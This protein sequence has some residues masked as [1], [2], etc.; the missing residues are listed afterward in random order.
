MYALQLSNTLVRL[1]IAG[2][3]DGHEKNK[4]FNFV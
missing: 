3:A 4:N 1:E 2:R